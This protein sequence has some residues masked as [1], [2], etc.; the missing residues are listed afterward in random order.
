MQYKYFR[1][2]EFQYALDLFENNPFEAKERFEAYLEKYPNDYYA[3]AYYV[4]LLA[5]LCLFDEAEEEYERI[6]EETRN[7]NFYS[8]SS[9]KKLNGFKCNMI[10]SKL[11]ILSA[12]EDYR[13]ILTILSKY[14]D[15]LGEL[16]QIYLSYYCRSK[17]GLLSKEL[18]GLNSNAYRFNQSVDYHEKLFREHIKKHEADYN[19][20][21][22]TPNIAIFSSDF[23]M[24]DIINEIKK[25]IPSSKR[26][27]PGYFE[28]AYYFQFDNCGR[29]NNKT[30]NYFKV[31][32]FHNTKNFITIYPT[33]EYRNMPCENLN[34]LKEKCET[35]HED[36]LSQIDKFNRRYNRK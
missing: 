32:C 14:H 31:I 7:N 36:R 4:M 3:R 17:L 23:P 22:E 35:K 24:D 9:I 2:T 1:E 11:K 19:M 34:Y 27:F 29:V 13:G 30:T 28:D 6:I 12:K 15:L 10:I 20:D 21:S 5:K 8:D 18:V 16:D 33:T 26:I 25:Y